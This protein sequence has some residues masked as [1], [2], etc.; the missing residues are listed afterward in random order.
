MWSAWGDEDEEV[1]YYG[2]SLKFSIK[3]SEII[4]QLKQELGFVSAWR[5]LSQSK[6]DLI[7]QKMNSFFQ[8][9]EY[10]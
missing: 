4:L 6:Y 3:C 7:M 8:P 5:T 1:K 2:Q 9:Q 10:I